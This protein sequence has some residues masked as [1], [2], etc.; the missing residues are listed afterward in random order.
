MQ[1]SIKIIP[2]DDED[3]ETDLLT[4]NKELWSTTDNGKTVNIVVEGHSGDKTEKV[5]IT[6]VSDLKIDQSCSSEED[7]EGKDEGELDAKKI[8]AYKNAKP[9][10][11]KALS[12][13]SSKILRS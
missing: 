7:E 4:V 8:A 12:N 10:I 13:K 1:C 2:V 11:E 6:G 5:K 9:F 3:V